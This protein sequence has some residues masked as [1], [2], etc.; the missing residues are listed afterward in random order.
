MFVF[1]IY[2]PGF[3][4]AVWLFVYVFYF[5]ITTC[6]WLM[7]VTMV[8]ER[9]KEDLELVWCLPFMPLFTFATRVWSAVAT[10]DEIFNKIHLDSSMA[11]WWVLKKTKF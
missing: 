2:D 4:L 9:K 10:L 11:P 5:F 3:V 1:L 8:S 7:A 6:L